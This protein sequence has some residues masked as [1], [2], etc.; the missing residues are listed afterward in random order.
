V[1][2]AEPIFPDFRRKLFNVP[3]FPCLLE[4]SFIRLLTENLLYLYG[5]YQKFIIKLDMFNFNT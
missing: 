4:N 2:S 1:R 3:F 5:F